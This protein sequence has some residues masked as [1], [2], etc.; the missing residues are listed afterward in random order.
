MRIDAIELFRIGLPLRKPIET[1]AGRFDKLETLLVRMESGGV[2]GWGEASPGNA[3]TAGAEWTA[4]ALAC[5]ATW[6]APRLV[7]S[8]VESGKDLQERLAAVRGNRHAKAAVDL[9]WWDLQA[10]LKGKPL[11]EL[12]GGSRPRV[13]VGVSFD[14]METI[15]ALLAAVGRAADA[16]F[17][18]V[19]LK[20]RPGWDVQMVNFVRSQ[21]PVLPIHIDCEGALGLQHMEM[22]CRL[23]DFSLAMVEQ[24]LPAEDLVGMAM[25]QDT[26]RT[27]VALDEAITTLE[28][29][30]MALELHSGKFVNLKLDRVGGLSTAQAIHDSAHQQCTPCFVGAT[31]QSGVGLRHAMAMASRPNCTYPAD[32]FDSEEVFEADLAEPVRPTPDP[33]SGKQSVD[34]SPHGGIGVEPN[35]EILERL[36]VETV[37]IPS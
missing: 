4:G 25:V 22:L 15:D 37:R 19:E 18:R 28:Q 7:G 2:S 20:F 6:L 14:R 35:R 32:W 29:A 21:F 30:E 5:A 36:T 31:L 11:H 23:D 1:P 17:A 9:A 33:E 12:L 3:P 27:P 26:V 8:M 16:G 10:R 34:L 24:P 13:E